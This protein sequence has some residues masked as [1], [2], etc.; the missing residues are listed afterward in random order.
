MG[1]HLSLKQLPINRNTLTIVLT[2]V[3]NGFGLIVN[4]NTDMM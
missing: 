2:D 3:N 1:K 4:P